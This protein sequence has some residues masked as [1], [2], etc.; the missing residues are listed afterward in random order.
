M[1]GDFDHDNDVD[2]VDLAYLHGRIGTAN[3][4]TRDS[5]DLTGDGAV[6]RGDV[7][8]FV[9]N[10]GRSYAEPTGGN[11]PAAAASA[12][13]R[14][15]AGQADVEHSPELIVRRRALRRNVLAT[16]A[17]LSD[18]TRTIG[19]RDSAANEQS[20]LHGSRGQRPSAI[21][22]AARSVTRALP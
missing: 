20:Q 19:D 1:F 14:N 7:A 4:A 15:A 18:L 17:A 6:N 11:S 21:R 16:D 3:G 8:R 22:T 2:L 10:F 5:G 13:V 9:R 12:I